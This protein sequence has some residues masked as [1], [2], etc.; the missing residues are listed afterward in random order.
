MVHWQP[1]LPAVQLAERNRRPLRSSVSAWLHDASPSEQTVLCHS[2][3]D[4]LAALVPALAE[5]TSSRHVRATTTMS[6][7]FRGVGR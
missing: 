5:V 6:T 2:F 1:V 4:T 3:I 7:F